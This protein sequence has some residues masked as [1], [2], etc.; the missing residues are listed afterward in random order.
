MSSFKAG[1]TGDSPEA[2]KKATISKSGAGKPA[3]RDAPGVQSGLSSHDAM[4]S[5]EGAPV[6]DFAR[7]PLTGNAGERIKPR[8]TK[9][10]S[11]KGKTFQLEN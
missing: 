6:Q 1:K 10:V 4:N 8:G 11:N 3:G 2:G 5:D 7:N 9:S